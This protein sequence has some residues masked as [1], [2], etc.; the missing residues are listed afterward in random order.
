[1]HWV[2]APQHALAFSLDSVEML[3]QFCIDF[4]RAHARDHGQAAG[5]VVRI[6][7]IDHAQQLIGFYAWP[8]LYANRIADA[9]AIFDMCT[10]KLRRTHADPREMRGKIEPTP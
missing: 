7:R 6:Q 4:P 9:A 5:L 2:A 8:D 10:V 3:R 1:M